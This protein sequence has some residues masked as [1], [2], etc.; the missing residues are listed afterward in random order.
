MSQNM[1]KILVI[2]L[3]IILSLFIVLP[4]LFRKTIPNKNYENNISKET[5]ICKKKAIDNFEITITTKYN[6]K[7][8]ETIDLKFVNK[9]KISSNSGQVN[10][11]SESRNLEKYYASLV[12]SYYRIVNNTSYINLSKET[13]QRYSKDKIIKSMFSSYS[14]AKKYYEDSGYTCK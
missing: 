3:I 1:K 14:K 4:P 12:G 5:L 11:S 9:S 10:I 2:I 6:K 13:Y 8:I 7:D